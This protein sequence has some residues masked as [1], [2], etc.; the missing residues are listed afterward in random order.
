MGAGPWVCLGGA[1]LPLGIP[2][3]W[4]RGG[5]SILPQLQ[6]RVGAVEDEVDP[7]TQEVEGS[8]A[9]SVTFEE[10]KEG[11]LQVAACPTGD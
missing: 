10:V 4:V 5:V 1:Q 11:G 3:P 2:V 7:L 8:S 6:T 9:A